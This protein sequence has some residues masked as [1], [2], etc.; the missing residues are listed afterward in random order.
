MGDRIKQ[1]AEDVRALPPVQKVLLFGVVGAALAGVFVFLVS[2]QRPSYVLL[3]SGLSSEDAAAVVD[4]MQSD[5]VPYRIAGGGGNILVP[6]DKVYEIRMRL[7]G[8][9][10]PRN[11]VGFEIFDKVQI[12]TTEFVQKMNYRRALEGELART[13]SQVRG[14]DRSRVHLSIPEETVFLED[15]QEASA[16][17]FLKLGAGVQLHAKQVQGIV[18]LVSGAVEGL[19]PDQVTVMDTLG[20]VLNGPRD[21]GFPAGLS[22]SQT[23]YQQRFERNLQTSIEAMLEKVI[24]QGK[25]VAQVRGSFNFEQVQKTEELYDPNVTAVRSEQTSKEK[26]SGTN[27]A[28]SGIPGT[29]SNIPG[30]GGGARSGAANNNFQRQNETLNYE[31]NKV[32]RHVVEPVGRLEKL[33]VA[34]LVDGT[35]Q[36]A[37]EG[38]EKTY[39]PRTE[40]ELGKYEALVKGIVGFDEAR[41][42][43]VHVENIP[44][45]T[46]LKGDWFDTETS[47]G[48][49]SPLMIVLLRYGLVALFGV[50]FLFFLVKP[51][52]SWLTSQP[53]IPGSF[54]ATVAELETALKGHRLPGMSGDT[55]EMRTAVQKLV[56]EDPALAT[57]LVREWLNEQR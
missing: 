53:G 7:A 34:V 30:E 23:E 47:G 40:E 24:G 19:Q 52:I 33:S 5:R 13:V 49:I 27:G 17:V 29:A 21:E 36:G 48:L 55:K 44:F 4:E 57:N 43:R 9:G 1:F 18:Y 46:D 14:V 25:V 11:G 42:D 15:R 10:L 22:S 2:V 8:K 16:S 35:Y 54:P 6:A 56:H 32:T 31:I 38:G 39:V 3:Y 28:A 26:S 51:L 45:E 37:A 41:G 12:G 50:L 20:R